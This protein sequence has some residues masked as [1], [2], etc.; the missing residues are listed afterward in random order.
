MENMKELNERFTNELK[1]IEQA[2]YKTFPNGAI[3]LGFR[4]II[5][6][7]FFYCNCYMIGNKKDWINGILDND[8]LSLKLMGFFDNENYSF[9]PQQ[10][11]LFSL[12]ARQNSFYIKSTN[13]NLVYDRVKIP[14]RK[15][16]GDIKK[17]VKTLEKT[18]LKAKK[19]ILENQNNFADKIDPKYITG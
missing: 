2:F 6:S 17:H 4:Q 3:N 1:A 11:E 19:L 18:F 7:P 5:G 15:T 8:P 9:R 12:E 10:N 14:Y 13:K 16:K